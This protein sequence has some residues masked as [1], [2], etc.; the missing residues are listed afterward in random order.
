MRVFFTTLRLLFGKGC[1]HDYLFGISFANLP[2][3]SILRKAMQSNHCLFV[4]LQIVI[5]KPWLLPCR[6]CHCHNPNCWRPNCR[7]LS[8]HQ[9]W[10]DLSL[11]TKNK[12]VFI[13]RP[14]LSDKS[15]NE[16]FRWKVTSVNI[17]NLNWFCPKH[18]IFIPLS[19]F[20]IDV[21]NH[22]S[23]EQAQQ[24]FHRFV[25]T[26]FWFLVFLRP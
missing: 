20:E 13:S 19:K 1:V 6:P 12:N 22:Q 3:N 5:T 21:F 4:A 9:G 2:R 18:W 16:R 7:W 24:F 26:A 17:W 10:F 11:E 8:R 23:L 14:F 25:P 15:R